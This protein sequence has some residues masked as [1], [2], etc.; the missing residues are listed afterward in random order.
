LRERLDAAARNR[1]L[2]VALS[3]RLPERPR[4]LD[5]GAGTGSL[6]RFLA[7]ILGR[8][9]SWVF[10]DADETLLQAGLVR[11]AE[12]AERRGLAAR[13]APGR[14]PSDLTLLT[15]VGTWRI[16]TSLADLARAPRGLPLTDVDAVVCSALLD[17]VSRQWLERLFSRLRRPFY[18]S[19][20]V[21]GRD[22]WFP[23]HP[24]D[25]AVRRAFRRD[26]HRDKGLG[27]ALGAEATRT[28]LQILAAKGFQTYEARSDWR[29][30]RGEARL[31]TLFAEMNARAAVQATPERRKRFKAWAA[32]R[33]G[34]AIAGKLAIR[35]GHRDILA[36]PPGDA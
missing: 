1:G 8:P 15:P 29:I 7:P 27:L 10:A 20:T 14:R 13:F 5:L 23:H 32:A 17:L 31:G 36:F 30:A 25:L 4:L 35:I 6:F 22:G 11:T 16:E 33:A 2:A 9:Q 34:Q 24:A 3:E 12:W 28:A 26:Q 21:D 19:L 18:A